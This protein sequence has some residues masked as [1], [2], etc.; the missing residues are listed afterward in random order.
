MILEQ[1]L[2]TVVMLLIGYIIG[3]FLEKRH[4]KSI[5]ERENRL[6]RVP[7][8]ATKRVIEPETIK[9]V[10]L[11]DGRVVI[12]VD[13]FKR[14]VAGMINIFG[15]RVSSYETLIDRARRE[16][17]LRMKSQ[18]VGASEIMNVKIETSSISK[19]DNRNIGSVEVYVYGTAI[20]R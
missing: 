11:V 20:Y 5:R 3:S 6:K 13:Y 7:I 9:D 8:L 1:I 12:S 2:I 4:Y 15:G 19:N 10:K 17:I 18:A 16:A 14:F